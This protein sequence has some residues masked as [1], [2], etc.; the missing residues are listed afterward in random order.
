MAG[1]DEA[2]RIWKRAN[3]SV[4]KYLGNPYKKGKFP[5]EFVLAVA[6]L[7]RYQHLVPDLYSKLPSSQHV[8]LFRAMAERFLDKSGK[9]K[10]EWEIRAMRVSLRSS[11]FEWLI[12]SSI[13]FKQIDRILNGTCEKKQQTAS[14]HED[15]A[16]VRKVLETCFATGLRPRSIIDLKRFRNAYSEQIGAEL[17]ENFPLHDA[18]LK[19]GLVQGEKVFPRP[20]GDSSGWKALVKDLFAKG[21]KILDCSRLMELHANELIAAGVPSV[22]VLRDLVRA[23]SVPVENP[24]ASV[25]IRESQVG[26]PEFVMWKDF[27]APMSETLDLEALILDSVDSDAL[28]IDENRLKELFRYVDPGDLHRLLVSSSQFVNNTDRTY[29]IASRVIFDGNEVDLAKERVSNGV[30]KAGYYSLAR[31][32]L[33]ESMT[34]NDPKL[35][36]AAAVRIFYH[37]YLSDSYDRH[38]Q[39]VFKSDG[40][41]FDSCIPLRE[42]CHSSKELHLEQIE[43]LFFDYNIAEVLGIA[44]LHEE[45]VRTSFNTFVNPELVSFEVDTIDRAIENLWQKPAIPLGPSLSFT[46]FPAIPGYVWNIYLLEAFLRRESKRFRLLTPSLAQKGVSGAIVQVSPEETDVFE[47]FAKVAVEAGIGNNEEDVGAY[48]LRMGYISRRSSKL[49]RKVLDKMRI[50]FEERKR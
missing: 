29:V 50:I 48:L 7:S 28:I 17:P 18:L 40:V 45:M 13:F 8:K 6:F 20:S 39:I 21:Y 16:D 36:T 24:A 44:T 19:V 3:S 23:E 27:F 34:L 11:L 22:E 9:A 15:F 47:V 42:A 12:L 1:N 43:R 37:R 10:P 25:Q 4:M 33:P 49:L 46:D 35:S 38:G 41:A 32:E 14:P 31:L 30:E 2:F 5:Y 26:A